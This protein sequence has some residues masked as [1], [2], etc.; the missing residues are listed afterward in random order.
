MKKHITSTQ[1][2]RSRNTLSILL[3]AALLAGTGAGLADEK[4][5][6]IVPP[7]AKYHG[8]TYREWSAAFWQ[9]ALAEPLEGHLFLDTA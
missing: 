2:F 8:K 6:A 4:Q 1:P 7:D 9:Y 3:L 5:V